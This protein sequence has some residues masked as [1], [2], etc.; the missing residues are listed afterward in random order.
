MDVDELEEGFVDV[1]AEFR[2]AVSG[3]DPVGGG[4]AVVNCGS[5]LLGAR[6]GIGFEEF[7]FDLGEGVFDGSSFL[8]DFEGEGGFEMGD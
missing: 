4:D 1:W 8:G 6:T 3:R 5:E 7:G 2:G